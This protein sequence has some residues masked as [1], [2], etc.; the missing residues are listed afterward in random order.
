MEAAWPSPS[1]SWLKVPCILYIFNL[2]AFRTFQI[3]FIMCF[4]C[5]FSLSSVCLY[6]SWH[7]ALEN[8]FTV[9]KIIDR[10]DCSD[11][12]ALVLINREKC[13]NTNT[14]VLINRK[15]HSYMIIIWRWDKLLWVR[16]RLSPVLSRFE[17]RSTAVEGEELALEGLVRKL[18]MLSPPYVLW[19]I[20]VVIFT[21]E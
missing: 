6:V 9:F 19:N 15:E 5:L 8:V 1:L 3:H 10:E 17:R 21:Y 20:F 16:V 13:S 12:N 7:N 11:T 18:L 4:H 14:L 2:Y